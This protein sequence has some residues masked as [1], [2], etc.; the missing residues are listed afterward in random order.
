MTIVLW[1]ISRNCYL[2]DKGQETRDKG[3]GVLQFCSLVVETRHCLVCTITCI[4]YGK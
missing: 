1:R 2:Y 3:Q 4:Y